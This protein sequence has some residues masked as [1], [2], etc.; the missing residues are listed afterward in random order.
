MAQK[1]RFSGTG[2]TGEEDGLTLEDAVKDS[3]LFLGKDYLKCSRIQSFGRTILYKKDKIR[4]VHTF[5][6]MLRF[7]FP[8]GCLDASMDAVDTL[9]DASAGF[10]AFGAVI[11]QGKSRLALGFVF[12]GVR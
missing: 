4:H 9:D 5:A 7:G 6:A 8:S 3:L 10:L 11:S 2:R 12:E 1:H